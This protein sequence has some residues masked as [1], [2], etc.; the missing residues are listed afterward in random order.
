M[1]V[2]RTRA[3]ALAA[4]TALTATA[5]AAPVVARADESRPYSFAVIGDVPYGDAAEQQFPA[6][7]AGST[8][9]RTCAR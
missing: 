9:T 7:I 6:F 1:T 3:L 5:V 2:R 8:P 4:A